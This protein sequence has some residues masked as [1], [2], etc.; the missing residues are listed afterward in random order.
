MASKKNERISIN[1]LE[2]YVKET[3]EECQLLDLGGGLE[4]I[5]K[6]TISITDVLRFTDDIVAACFMEDG[7]FTPET[8]DFMVKRGIM[9]YYANFNLPKNIEKQYSLVCGSDIADMLVGHI[10][11][12]QLQEIVSAANRKLE[13]QLKQDVSDTLLKVGALVDV[14]S[15]FLELFSE[16]ASGFDGQEMSGILDVFKNMNDSEEP[17]QNKIVAAYVDLM[18]KN[19]SEKDGEMNHHLQ[20]VKTGHMTPLEVVEEDSPDD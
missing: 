5:V 18:A 13:Q 14:A 3:V 4:V 20:L 8:F 16:K 15:S 17:M 19:D 2:K 11:Q 6:R 9:V 1:A 7:T 12:R 10:N